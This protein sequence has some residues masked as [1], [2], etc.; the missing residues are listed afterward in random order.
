MCW[1]LLLTL[2]IVCCGSP[3]GMA[4]DIGVNANLLAMSSISAAEVAGGRA[5]RARLATSARAAIP[6]SCLRNQ[7]RVADTN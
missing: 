5:I 1:Y 7:P 4:I 3:G 6:G 2:R